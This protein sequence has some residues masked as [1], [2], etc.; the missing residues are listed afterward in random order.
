[1]VSVMKPAKR[2]FDWLIVD[3]PQFINVLKLEQL[4]NKNYFLEKEKTKTTNLPHS[5]TLLSG[6]NR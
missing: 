3:K 1:M 5:Q 6:Q 2:C 4:T